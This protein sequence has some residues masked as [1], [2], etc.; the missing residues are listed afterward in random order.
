M[1]V[2]AVVSEG[3]LNRHGTKGLSDGLQHSLV[4]VP[5]RDEMR[6]NDDLST[7]LEAEKWRCQFVDNDNYR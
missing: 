7:L 4:V 2:H 6:D 5:C 1:T 3:L